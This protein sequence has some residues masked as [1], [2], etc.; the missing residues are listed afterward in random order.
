MQTVLA[1]LLSAIVGFLFGLRYRVVAIAFVAPIIALAVAIILRHSHFVLA[2]V[3]VFASLSVSQIAYLIGTWLRYQS[4]T[5]QF[6]DR[7]CS[8]R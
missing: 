4:T 6:D 2:V 7:Y 3:I 5:E 8:D 1:L